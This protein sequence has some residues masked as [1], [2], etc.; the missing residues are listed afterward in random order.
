MRGARR[1]VE[2]DDEDEAA[3]NCQTASLAG[4]AA[5]LVLVVLGLFLIHV[6]RHEAQVE[7][8]LMAGRLDCDAIA[9]T[10]R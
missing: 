3:A 2:R 6:L 8:C 9:V 5:A 1:W 4:L 10:A 7:D